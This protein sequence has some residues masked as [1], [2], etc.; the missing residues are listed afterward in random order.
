MEDAAAH[1]SSEISGVAG[2]DGEDKDTNGQTLLRPEDNSAGYI[3]TA[4]IH[5]RPTNSVILIII[6]NNQTEN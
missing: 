6:K 5:K 4:G 3:P 2:G 1:R